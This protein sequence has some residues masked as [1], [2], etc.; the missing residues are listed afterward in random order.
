MI[1]EIN[2]LAI[3]LMQKQHLTKYNTF[4][5]ENTQKLGIEGNFPK[6]KKGIY[7]KLHS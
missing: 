7:E 1:K 6:Q 3:Q 5:D 2:H 4:Y